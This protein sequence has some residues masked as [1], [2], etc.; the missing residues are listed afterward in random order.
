M[1][2]PATSLERL[3]QEAAAN[4]GA[5][6]HGEEGERYTAVNSEKNRPL[7]ENRVKVYP[8]LVHGTFRRLKW[9]VMVATL[10][11]YYVTPW[12]RWERGPGLP[13]QAVLLDF[14]GRRFYFFFL[15][16]WPQEF[17]YITG[18]LILA[19]LGLFLVTSIAGRVWCGYTC[20]QTVWTDRAFRADDLHAG[21]PR[22][23]TGLHLHVPLATHPGCDVR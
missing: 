20:P 17:Y 21:R 7:Y 16:I 4:A 1:T 14:P 22:A 9:L 12:L 18:L 23:R 8:K 10:T 19:A 6:P 11:I 3:A 13:D 2:D 15:E 5:N